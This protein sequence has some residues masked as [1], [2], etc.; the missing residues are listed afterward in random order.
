MIKN[1]IHSFKQHVKSMSK[2]RLAN[3]L[4]HLEQELNN[5]YSNPKSQSIYNDLEK[6]HQIDENLKS[7]YYD[8]LKKLED[9]KEKEKELSSINPRL[10]ELYHLGECNY[11]YNGSI[12][13]ILEAER[14]VEN[15]KYELDKLESNNPELRSLRR[16]DGT[17]NEAFLSLHQTN[18][19]QRKIQI[20]KN[21]ILKREQENS[22]EQLS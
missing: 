15:L 9:A 3:L 22:P 1:K 7:K 10:Y 4:E 5:T 21:E 19:I 11:Y 16:I 14:L 17:N 18:I 2:N 8:I 20:I 12:S 6:S 13:E